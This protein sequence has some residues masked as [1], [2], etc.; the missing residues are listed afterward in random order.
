MVGAYASLKIVNPLDENNHVGPLIDSAAVKDFLNALE[1]VQEEGGKVICGGS[2]VEGEGCASN[3]YVVPAV[4]EV[5]ISYKSNRR[6]PR[7]RF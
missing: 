2:V 7:I 6:W 1:K 4:A 5:L 3:Y